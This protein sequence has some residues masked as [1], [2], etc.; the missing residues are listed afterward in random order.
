M[1]EET[2]ALVLG[3]LLGF[4]AAVVYELKFL[5]RIDRNMRAMLEKIKN[6]EVVE[7]KEIA[8]QEDILEDIQEELE[9]KGKRKAKKRSKR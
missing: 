7:L 1:V 2:L 5:I 3:I 6:M 4:A 9:D 8:K